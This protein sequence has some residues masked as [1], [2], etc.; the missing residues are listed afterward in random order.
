MD[1]I[2]KL[3]AGVAHDFNNLLSVIQGNLE[4]LQQDLDEPEQ[5]TLVMEA[6]SAAKRGAIL[7]SQLLSY[8]RKTNW[9]PVK[10]NLDEAVREISAMVHRVIPASIKIVN[11]PTTD[12]WPAHLDRNQLDSVSATALK[13]ETYS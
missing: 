11:Q 1:A 9:E 5:K 3:V 8:S 4:F 12:L 6:F 2:G 10:V 7:T 13:P